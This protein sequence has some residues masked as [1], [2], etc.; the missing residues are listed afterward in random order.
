MKM[1]W[2]WNKVDLDVLD[3]DCFITYVKKAGS[4]TFHVIEI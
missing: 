4:T 2:K 1:K 3:L